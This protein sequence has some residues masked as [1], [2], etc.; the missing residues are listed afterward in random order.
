LY[1]GERRVSDD[2]AL[3]EPPLLEGAV[4][5]V[6]R[7]GLAEPR[8]LLE[9]HVVAGPDSGAVHRLLPG[10][11]GIG[12]SVEATVRIDDPDASRLH[13]VLRVAT[14]GSGTT[15]HDLASTNGTTVDDE[16][17]PGTGRAFPP[18]SVLRVGDTRL[19]L[20]MPE[21]VPVSCRPDGAGHLA[22]NRPPRHVRIEISISSFI[23]WRS[24]IFWRRTKRC[25]RRAPSSKG[26]RRSRRKENFRPISDS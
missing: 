10:E 12:R 2:D 13:A 15:V 8:G 20:A 11:H 17:V 25:S 4:L 14:D 3:G 23:R 22:M 7:P 9:L 21:V 24:P 1:A 16:P 26:P 19:R 5:T 18:G 6:D